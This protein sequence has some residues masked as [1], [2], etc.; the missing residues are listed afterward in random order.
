MV[1]KPTRVKPT[2]SE[3]T[4]SMYSNH[5]MPP[6]TNQNLNLT[7]GGR[8]W[9]GYRV[10]CRIN[11]TKNGKSNVVSC[12]FTGH[13]SQLIHLHGPKRRAGTNPGIWLYRPDFLPT[14]LDHL[15]SN[16]PY[17]SFIYKVCEGEDIMV[18]RY[19]GRIPGWL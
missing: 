7:P 6:A 1:S 2:V 16:G 10:G 13:R 15:T 12:H 8:D 3:P 11:T 4:T 17:F 9:T 19:K 14:Q 18:L 5:A